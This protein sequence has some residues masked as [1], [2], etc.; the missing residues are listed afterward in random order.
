MK[1]GSWPEWFIMV[2]AFSILLGMAGCSSLFPP[3]ENPDTPGDSTPDNPETPEDPADTGINFTLPDLKGK[4]V[5]LLEFRGTPVLVVFLKSYCNKCEDE[6]PAIQ[7]VY[8]RH[9]GELQVLGVAVNERGTSGDLIASPE[10]YAQIIR[11]NFVNKYNWTFPVL[12]DDYGKVQRECVV[13]LGVPAFLFLNEKGE[14][15]HTVT[16]AVSENNLES[17]LYRYLL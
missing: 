5:S 16:G 2:L 10:Q 6:A 12:I 9:Q 15:R 11:A 8:R 13:K 17:L 1:K 7:D 14:I 3:E 4:E